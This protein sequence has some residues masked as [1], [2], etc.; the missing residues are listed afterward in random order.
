VESS[1]VVLVRGVR[2]RLT[3]YKS[4][5]GGVTKTSGGATRVGMNDVELM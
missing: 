1:F 3:D 4:D 2:E 5:N